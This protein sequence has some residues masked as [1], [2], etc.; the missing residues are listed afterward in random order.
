MLTN[1]AFGRQVTWT[2]DLIIPPGHQMTFKD[3]LHV[4]SSGLIFK[5]V[6]PKWAV[7]LTERTRK[8]NLAFIEMKVPYATLVSVVS[9]TADE[10]DSNIW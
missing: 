6:L 3:A 8:I 1:L 5:I 9:P 10:S 2:S 4:L 7:N